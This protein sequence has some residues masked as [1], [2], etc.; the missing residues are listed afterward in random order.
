MLKTLLDAFWSEALWLPPNVTWSDVAPGPRPGTAVVYTDH[1]HLWLTVPMAL[2]L[3]MLRFV[4]DKYIFAPFG[5]ALGIKHDRN[6]EVPPNH[7]LEA[8][9]KANP[10]SK[11]LCAL[12]KQL[13]LSERQVQRWWRRRRLQDKPSTLVKFRESCWRATFY[14]YNLM[15]GWMVLWDKE[16]LWDVDYCYIGYPHQGVTNDI[17]WLYIVALGFYLSQT[18][19]LYVDVR[20]KDFWQ[21][22]VHHAAT[23]SL[24]SFSWVCNLH[25]IGSLLMLTL[26][27][28]EALLEPTKAT[29]YAGYHRASEYMFTAFTALWIV[30][31]IGMYSYFIIGSA[32]YRAAA[33]FSPFLMFQLLVFL[34][35]VL[36][37]LNLYWTWLILQVAYRAIKHGQI[38]GDIRSSSSEASDSSTTHAPNRDRQIGI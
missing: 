37:A 33:Y 13:D 21:L 19:S 32:T 28:S 35:W 38:D 14:F 34:A 2:I 31:R 7:K 27:C 3:I 36:L 6:I 11:Q 4:L 24:L 17:E 8:A 22:V 12:A 18:L 23:L 15:V 1:R 9:Y 29:K 16:W 25:R 30:T 20:R 26:D 5:K 10:A